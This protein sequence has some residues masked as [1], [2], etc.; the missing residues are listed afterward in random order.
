MQIGVSCHFLEGGKLFVEASFPCVLL[1]RILGALPL[2]AHDV[3]GARGVTFEAPPLTLVFQY[4]TLRSRKKGG[5]TFAIFDFW[6]TQ[7]PL[8]YDS[9]IRWL[10]PTP[11]FLS[12]L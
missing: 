5:L 3:H 4:L 6:F 1:S 11:R 12:P 7:L 10:P 2:P 8:E 9:N